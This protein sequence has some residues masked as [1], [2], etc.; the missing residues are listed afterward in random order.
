MAA[1]SSVSAGK[2]SGGRHLNASCIGRLFPTAP[3]QNAFHLSLRLF[4]YVHFFA[5]AVNWRMV[6]FMFS[7]SNGGRRV[8]RRRR[9]SNDRMIA[10]LPYL[11]YYYLRIHMDGQIRSGYG[12][13]AD[14]ADRHFCLLA[15]GCA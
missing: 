2:H 7:P 13:T 11:P 3:P 1:V 15:L 14:R 4:S 12:E 6:V 9:S 8:R 10:L 5:C